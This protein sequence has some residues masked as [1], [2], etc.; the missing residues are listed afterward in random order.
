MKF[1]EYKNSSFVLTLEQNNNALGKQRQR[2]RK[3][4]ERDREDSGRDR[5]IGERCRDRARRKRQR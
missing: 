2:K 3:R 4:R 5:V 1:S